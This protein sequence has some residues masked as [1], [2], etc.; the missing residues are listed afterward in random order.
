MGE[1]PGV[2]MARTGARNHG[3]PRS[4]ARHVRLLERECQCIGCG[5]TDSHA[6][7]EPFL[8]QPCSW[9]VVDRAAGVGICSECP[10][11]VD[12]WQR[13]DRTVKGGAR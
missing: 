5:C 11:E 13:G 1:M 10:T 7:I 6:C 2:C 8:E 12:R 3:R 4:D 9:L